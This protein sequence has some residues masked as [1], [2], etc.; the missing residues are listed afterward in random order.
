MAGKHGTRYSGY[1]FCQ[2]PAYATALSFPYNKGVKGCTDFQLHV[3]QNLYIYIYLYVLMCVKSSIC[4]PGG[5]RGHCDIGYLHTL[6][7]CNEFIVHCK[8]YSRKETIRLQAALSYPY[9]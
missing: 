1:S 7:R 3:E 5:D 6:R 4:T 9:S 8:N 2:T